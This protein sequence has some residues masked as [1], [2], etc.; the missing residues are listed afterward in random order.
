MEVGAAMSTVGEEQR[1]SRY[2]RR[3]FLKRAGA[4][5]GAVAL[6]GGVGAAMAPR[7]VAARSATVSTSPT[8]FG[9]IFPNLP[10]FAAATDA[11]RVALAELGRRGG[12]LDANDDLSKGPVLLI[13]DPSLST[14]NP[15][16]PTHTAGTTFFGQFVDHDITFDTTS[17][18][19]FTTDPAV[20]PNS[21][22]PS[23]DLDSVY[24]EGPVA[25]PQLYDPADRDKLRVGFGGQF[26]DLPRADDGTNTAILPDPRNDE[27]LIIAG[28]QCAFILF[29]NNAVDWAREHGYDGGSTFR[30]ARQLTTWHYHWL[31]VHE[32]LPQI[33]GQEMV[34]D[35]LKNR[36]RFYKPGMRKGFI[37]VEFQAAAYR[38]G[39]SMVRPSY[40][41]NLHGDDGDPFFGMVFDPAAEGQSDPIDLRGGAR[42]PRRFIGWQTFFDFGDGNVKPNKRIDTKISTPLFKLPLG[43]IASHDPPEALPQRNLLR[44]LTWSLPSGQAVA[45]TMG[46]TPLADGDLSELHP[47]GF[48]SSTPLWYYVL[49][50][51]ELVEDGLHLGPVGGRIVA[52]VLIGLLQ[53]DTGSYLVQK[54]RWTPTLTSA[55]AFR[56][57]DF[58]TFA[59]VDPASRGQ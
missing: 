37:P 18:L 5:A 49:K 23:L 35:V 26:E 42:A 32:F 46:V 8:T 40:R 56:M 2:S 9:R 33:I 22:T 15:N 51:A 3:E 31:V 38:F 45:A 50:E 11:V 55:G 21:R 10:P 1:S 12:L 16:N 20:S 25:S 19:G 34:D 52:E 53:S 6:S 27:N 48:Q 57:K 4:G 30:Q 7:A 43:V 54:P 58:L 47:Y 36:R 44:Q 39:H 24:G 17:R 14:N 41:A 13:T 28:L 59:G 29:H